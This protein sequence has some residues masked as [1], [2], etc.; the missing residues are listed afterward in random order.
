MVSNGTTTEKEYLLVGLTGSI[1]AGKSTVAEIFR[2]E[3]I[4][5]IAADRVAKDLMHSDPDLKRELVEIAGPEV[6]RNGELD[7]AYLADLI[8]SDPDVR[9]R[10]ND[11]V[12]PRTIAQQ[13]VMARSEIEK[14]ARVVA[15]EAALIFETDGEERFDYIVVVDAEPQV[16]MERASERDGVPIDKISQREESQ[17]PAEEKVKRADFVIR[18]D[19]GIDEL[20]RNTLLIVSLLKVLPPRTQLDESSDPQPGE[21]EE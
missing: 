6:Y 5:V 16:R 17:M 12:H 2:R 20:E 1:G 10:V 14:G 21:E 19:G 4:P 3:G 18:N 9:E 7:R 13:G 15:C 8:F 11:A